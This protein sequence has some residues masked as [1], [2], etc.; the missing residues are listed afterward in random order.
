MPRIEMEMAPSN[1]SPLDPI[2]AEIVGA[3]GTEAAV[4]LALNPK[5]S[6]FEVESPNSCSIIAARQDHE[7]MQGKFREHDIAV[8]DMRKVIGEE[9][10]KRNRVYKTRNQLL[11]ELNHRTQ[12]FH[13]QSGYGD[14]ARIAQETEALL[15]RDIEQMGLEPALAINAALNNCIDINGKARRVSKKS[16]P[17]GNFMFWRD[18][19][20]TTGDQLRTHRMRFSIRRQEVDLAQLGF[21]AL[22][23]AYTPVLEKGQRGT[24]EGGD[25]LPMEING[26]LFALIGQAERTSKAGVDAW[27]RSHKKLWELTGEGI[28]PAVVEGP[29]KDTQKEMHLDTYSQQFS[30]GGIVYCGEVAQNRT[31]RI[32]V[33]HGDE[34]E[35]I[36]PEQYRH[37]IERMFTQGYN[38]SKAEQENYAPNVIVDGG[39]TVYIT[40]DGTDNVTDFI[41]NN[42][43]ET[44]LL[45][46]NNLTQCYGGA[47]CATSEIRR[48]R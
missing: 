28:I 45:R 32:L 38:M 9:M 37:W 46:M 39:H 21:K 47:H 26:Q 5:K 40:R 23:L 22:G 36:D 27:F 3:P 16:L 41:S 14:V 44:V 31:I 48:R 2:A 10:A 15:D 17:M 18:T 1:Y 13:D 42:V 24:I 20:H 29:K 4:A 43:A 19:N 25:V 12:V 33:E 8:F 11:A 7:R 35:R 30:R 34:I 6:L